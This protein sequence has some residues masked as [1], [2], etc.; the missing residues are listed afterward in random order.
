MC[1]GGEAPR[2][3]QFVAVLTEHANAGR[4]APGSLWDLRRQQIHTKEWI[5]SIST[6]L[7]FSNLLMHV[8]F[9]CDKNFSELGVMFLQLLNECVCLCAEVVEVFHFVSKY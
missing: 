6:A 3:Q 7:P 8:S 2:P 4:R 1:N 9:V 5:C